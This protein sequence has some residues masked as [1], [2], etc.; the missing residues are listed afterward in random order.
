MKPA[1][2]KFP[3]NTK[4]FANLLFSTRQPM[5]SFLTFP[6]TNPTPPQ[7][8]HPSHSNSPLDSVSYTKLV[9]S[10]IKT[11]SLI[12]GKL[13]HSHMIKTSFKPCLFLLNNLLLM[14]GKFCEICTAQNLFDKMP[15]RNIISYNS[16]ISGYSKMGFYAKVLHAFSEARMIGL[17]VDKFTYAGALGVCGQTGNI[18]LGKLI[19]GLVIVSG[20]SEHVFLINSLIDMYSK[21]GQVDQARL[22]FECSRDLDDVSW[23]SLIAGYVRM[24]ANEEVS[25]LVRKMHRSGFRLNTYTLGSALKACT[26]FMFSE[27][28]GKLV[29]GYTI[30]LGLDLDVVVGTALLDM[31][32]KAGYLS[33]AI[34]IFRFIPNHNIIMYNAMI[35]GFLQTE[36]ISGAFAQEAVNLFLEMQRQGMNPSKFTFSSILKAC[37]VFETF[38]FGK[39]IHA[40]ICKRSLQSDE[41]IG[42][43]LIDFY[44]VSGLTE[45]GLRCFNSTPKLDVV[46]WTSMIAGYVQNRQFENA[47][48]LFH[49]LLAS[50]KK[51][52]EFVISSVLSACAN[53]AAARPGE[54]I[55][56]YAV[57]SG[58]EK[59]TIIQNAQICMYAKSGEIESAHLTFKET[60]DP[61][62]VTWSVMISS[63]AQH[64]CA[65]EALRLFDLMTGCD[66][67]PNHITFLGVLTACSHGGL[68]EEGLRYFEIMK[69]DYGIA[70]NV[71]HCACIVDLL[72]R[73]GRL[74]EA[75][76]FILESVFADDPVMWR[77]LLSACRVHKDPVMGKHIADR[78][79]ELEP[80]ASSSYVL[81]YNIYTDAGIEVPAIEVRKMMQDRGVKK[82]PGISWIEVGNKVHSFV[83]GDRSHPMCQLIYARL[84]EILVKVKKIGF[85][86][87]RLLFS[88]SELE[89]KDS[90]AVNYHSEKLAVT[91]GIISFPRSA[92]VRVMKNLRVCLGCHMTMKLISEVEKR[93]II[94]RDPIRFH[95]FK[96]GSC[97]CK[98][99]W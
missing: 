89:F 78:V 64:G 20:S 93:E 84:D 88:T 74:E 3:S 80:Q 91:F 71:K 96:E 54:L 32:A 70:T 99:Y 26:N 45:D 38:E 68:V 52:D 23:N 2:F 50:G 28:Y 73:A 79:I 51:P 19:H 53:L 21:C 66:V 43:A 83:V 77:A 46:S 57:K 5:N 94:L 98:D 58:V 65:K 95:H 33:D 75:Q 49:Q 72:G 87:L 44:F 82:E 16:L 69:R 6:E 27:Q 15:K 1:K 81:L 55:Q 36:T 25:R 40:Q 56:G 24:G 30:K 92:P 67:D 31:Y 17:K 48:A 4:D 90:T 61:D 10:S 22:L 60:E 11:G 42:S 34:Q 47:L 29:H 97:S 35:A 76:K 59:S 12:H 85:N 9:Q 7:Y 86:D 63:Y 14:Y 39:Q 18:E 8:T 41:F 13:A 37:I 62:V